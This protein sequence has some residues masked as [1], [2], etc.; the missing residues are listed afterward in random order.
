MA[1][2]IF[3][4]VQHQLVQTVKER[5]AKKKSDLLLLVDMEGAEIR[6]GWLHFWAEEEDDPFFL[7]LLHFT[8]SVQYSV[9]KSVNGVGGQIFACLSPFLPK[10]KNFSERQGKMS[11]LR[12]GRPVGRRRSYLVYRVVQYLLPQEFGFICSVLEL[13]QCWNISRNHLDLG[14]PYGSRPF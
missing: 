11:V 4:T 9:K 2:D 12:P 5:R 14:S 10:L 1:S 8:N 6:S 3:S 13:D 7:L